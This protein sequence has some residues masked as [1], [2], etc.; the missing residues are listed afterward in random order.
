M[1]DEVKIDEEIFK[2]FLDIENMRLYVY[3]N[4]DMKFIKGE[5]TKKL[6]VIS[7]NVI[8]IDTT[9]NHVNVEISYYSVLYG[10]DFHGYDY[11]D[12]VK[13][14]SKIQYCSQ[15]LDEFLT[16]KASVGE[17]I[18]EEEKN[19]SLKCNKKE[20]ELNIIRKNYIE[21]YYYDRNNKSF[22]ECKF[23]STEDWE[24]IY[25]LCI[26]I[27]KYLNI[28]LYVK[29]IDIP[30][31]R[32]FDSENVELGKLIISKSLYEKND[33]FVRCGVYEGSV[34][35]NTGKILEFLCKDNTINLS[36]IKEPIK[37]NKEFDTK[38]IYDL[39]SAFEVESNYKYKRKDKDEIQEN[40]KEK[41]IDYCKTLEEYSEQKNFIDGLINNRIIDYGIG[42]GHREKINKAI[43]EYL[44][45]FPER[46]E[47]YG[48]VEQKDEIIKTVYELRTKIIHNNFIGKLKDDQNR[49][50]EYFE[51]LVYAMQLKRIGIENKD[52]EEILDHVFG[53]G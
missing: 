28:A 41:I 40:I 21:E 6:I 30:T 11:N 24:F 22:I 50:L 31:I 1:F 48:L 38:Q 17:K 3:E 39:Y 2:V 27:E 46:T 29:N 19:F 10:F 26:I 36:N 37:Y 12:G 5:E 45:V 34:E 51:W 33:N 18:K 44:N 25:N 20:F 15:M 43:E 14:I 32:I 16:P 35:R 23:V 53:V 4:I 52:I 42:Y 7:K 13:A 8:C 9:R 49:H 47:F